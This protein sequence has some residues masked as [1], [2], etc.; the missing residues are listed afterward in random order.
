M[1]VEDLAAAAPGRLLTPREVERHVA[2]AAVDAFRDDRLRVLAEHRDVARVI[3]GD[4]AAEAT[5][6]AFAAE[7]PPT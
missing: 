1:S 2:A 7:A 4:V 3:H 5:L 6:A